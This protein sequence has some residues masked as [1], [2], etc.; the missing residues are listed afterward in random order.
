MKF[1]KTFVQ[2]KLKLVL[3]VICFA[4]FCSVQNSCKKDEPLDVKDPDT[5]EFG[6]GAYLSEKEVTVSNLGGDIEIKFI[7]LGKWH[8]TCDQDWVQLNKIVG[9]DG[10]AAPTIT[11]GPNP[12]STDDRV[13]TLTVSVD[14][15]TESVSIKLTQ[16]AKDESEKIGAV[17]NVWISD[18]MRDTYLW[19]KEFVEIEPTLNYH[20][21]D[22]VAFLN[23]ALRKISG[24][25]DDGSIGVDGTRDYYSSLNVFSFI[26]QSVATSR[27]EMNEGSKNYQLAP[28][29]D[30]GFSLLYPVN[31]G[32]GNYYL[33][34]GGVN[35]ES[36]ADSEG[37]N[38]GDYITRYNGQILTDYTIGNAYNTLMGY[39]MDEEIVKLGWSRYKETAKNNYELNDKGDVYLSL[40]QYSFDP[41]MFKGVMQS[42]AGGKKVAYISYSAFDQ[43]SDFQLIETFKNIKNVGAEELILDLRINLGGDVQASTTM[44]SLIA[45]KEHRG[46]VYCDM[47]FNELRTSRGEKGTFYLGENPG[48]EGLDYP[49]IKEA[50]DN[51][52]ELKR[53]YV[54]TSYFTASASELII[55]GLRGIDI[56][57]YVVGQTTEGKNV[58]MEVSLSNDPQFSDYKF[59]ENMVYEFAPI[60]FRNLNAKGESNFTDGF[61]PD[62]EYIDTK[63]IVFDWGTLG[64]EIDLG[65]LAIF[66]HINT[67]RWPI[68]NKT[69]RC[70]SIGGKQS[71]PQPVQ[72]PGL[73][74]RGGGSKVYKY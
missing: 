44:A 34:I 41:I 60:T 49:L 59:E 45:P 24:N 58:G 17:A 25:E 33:L 9:L 43:F 66:E 27:K 50:M 21:P 48:I 10:D 26:P 19:N 38:R 52:L 28:K 46:K 47:Q 11:I 64:D 54:I 5:E 40:S 68:I 23:S 7:S 62:F 1:S 2:G 8:L 30:F 3:M 35:P 53:V 22:P 13:A 42:Q 55:N 36:P 4:L 74:P 37:F 61:T 32:D 20:N 31:L 70:S 12:S 15:F 63:S 57:V 69:A 71:L 18:L 29:T 14:G 72:I 67:G 56:P 6:V 51:S 39:T 65:I 16:Q 73:S